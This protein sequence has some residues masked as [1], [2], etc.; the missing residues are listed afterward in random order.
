MPPT[1]EVPPAKPFDKRELIW[2]AGPEIAGFVAVLFAI[3]YIISRLVTIH[4]ERATDSEK[5]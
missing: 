3:P 1:P 4:R 2:F 5:L